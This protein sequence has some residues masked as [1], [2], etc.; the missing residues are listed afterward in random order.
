[1]SQ[2][3]SVSRPM[4]ETPERS[5]SRAPSST[6]RAISALTASISISVERAI[7]GL[8]E[9]MSHVGDDATE[10]RGHAGIGRDQRRLQPDLLH[11]RAGVQSPASAERHQREIARIVAALDRDQ[12]DRAG[13]AAVGNTHDRLG[14]SDRV[15]AQRLADM[16]ARWPPSPP[17]HS[18][19][20]EPAADRPFRIDASEHDVGIRQCRPLVALAV[21]NRTRHRARR[22][23]PDLQQPAA[24]DGGDRSAARADGRDLDHRRAHDETE[25]D[26][27]L[28][29]KRRLPACDQRNVEAGAA[30]IAGDDVWEA[31]RL[32]RYARRR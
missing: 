1:M 9:V 30:D 17:R 20:V 5:S 23:R 24:I 3:T 11:Q 14:G 19:R 15:E 2:A 4:K 27:R 16:T 8:H 22:F 32:P 21:A 31:R 7:D 6:M 13:H 28:R 26:G 10:R 29:G 18:R 12:A 25:I